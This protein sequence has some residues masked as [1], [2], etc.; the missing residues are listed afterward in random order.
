MIH[1]LKPCIVIGHG[2]LIANS[3]NGTATFMNYGK[4]ILQGITTIP[5]RH[6]AIAL[7]Y[8]FNCTGKVAVWGAH[9]YFKDVYNLHFQVWRQEE[10]ASEGN[11]SLSN[12][13]REY[14]LI[15]QNAFTSVFPT[16]GV[17]L[18]TPLPE[19]Q[20]HFEQGDVVGL[21]VSGVWKDRGIVMLTS[22]QGYGTEEVWV[23]DSEGD[24]P[25][26]GDCVCSCF[27]R[28]AIRITVDR[29]TN[30]APVMSVSVLTADTGTYTISLFKIT[31]CLY[32]NS[33]RSPII[34]TGSTGTKIIEPPSNISRGGWCTYAC[35]KYVLIHCTRIYTS[36]TYINK[37]E[38][39]ERGHNNQPVDK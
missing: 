25:V 18:A 33:C 17:I 2:C 9:V 24:P 39:R 20:V 6:Q 4:D 26:D 10:A 29:V 14:A 12:G 27:N 22:D 36:L 13:T 28:G 1:T 38:R 34:A 35:S 30:A 8:K 15:G 7:S 16:S 19:K 21:Y 23:E 3:E 11:S 5:H 31:A 37:Q 32:S